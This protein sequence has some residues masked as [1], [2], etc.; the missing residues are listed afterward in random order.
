QRV[1]VDLTG[2]LRGWIGRALMPRV[3]DVM[4]ARSA[5]ILRRLFADPRL[6]VIRRS[7]LSFVRRA[8]R[9]AAGYGV[10]ATVVQALARPDAARARAD[11]IG[12]D[13][14][15]RLVLRATATATE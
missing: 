11:R 9:V 2:V 15:A 7:P 5:A 1:F 12:A 13:L 14:A 6:S 8:L 4:E 3:L 10:P